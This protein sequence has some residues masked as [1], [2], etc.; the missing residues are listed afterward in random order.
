MEP[1]CVRSPAILGL[2]VNCDTSVAAIMIT[3][4]SAAGDP[5]AEN[6]RTRAARVEGKSLH[7]LSRP[8]ACASTQIPPAPRLGRRL[9]S[10]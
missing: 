6:Q 4:H 5:K 9:A 8:N 10:T 3:T 1:I 2:T 7:K